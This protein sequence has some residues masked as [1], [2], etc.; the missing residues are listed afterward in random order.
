MFY[1]LVGQEVQVLAIVAKTEAAIWLAAS[2]EAAPRSR[3]RGG[4]RRLVPLSAVGG[5]GRASRRAPDV[6]HAAR[7]HLVRAQPRRCA[8]LA[9]TA[10]TLR[11]HRA[12]HALVTVIGVLPK[13]FTDGNVRDCRSPAPRDARSG[14]EPEQAVVSTSAQTT[15]AHDRRSMRSWHQCEPLM[16]FTP[17]VSGAACCIQ[18]YVYEPQLRDSYFPPSRRNLSQIRWKSAGT[19]TLR[20]VIAPSGR[21][22]ST[23]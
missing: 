12:F 18:P 17:K 7:P 8:L 13:S 20:L 14:V 10:P 15:I 5:A 3:P 21:H 19:S 1:D 2:G 22:S 11:P 9:R 4:E 23:A 6:P 16:T